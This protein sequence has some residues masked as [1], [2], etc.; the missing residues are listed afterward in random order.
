MDKLL[1]EDDSNENGL[2]EYTEFMTAFNL[3]RLEKVKIKKASK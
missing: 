3:G 1:E 2:I